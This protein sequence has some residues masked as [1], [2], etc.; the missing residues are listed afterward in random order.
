MQHHLVFLIVACLETW[1]K[2]QEHGPCPGR[3][4]GGVAV[5]LYAL[6]LLAVLPSLDYL[7]EV[8]LVDDA[9]MALGE[10]FD[11]SDPFNISGGLKHLLT[12]ACALTDPGYLDQVQRV[13]VLLQFFPL[14]KRGMTLLDLLPLGT[15]LQ[16]LG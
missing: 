11:D 14:E 3:K 2:F 12:E 7:V 4:E 8:M 10:A 6:L 15:R 13:Q 1:N 5:E 9:Q 16:L